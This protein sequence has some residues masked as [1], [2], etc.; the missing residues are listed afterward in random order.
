MNP[1]RI[2]RKLMMDV[3]GFSKTETNGLITLLM[4]VIVAAILPRT[5]KDKSVASVQSDITQW[6]DQIESSIAMSAKPLEEQ[7][8]APVIRDSFDPNTTSLDRMVSVGVPELIAKRITL[9]REKGGRFHS[10]E[11]IGKI[12]G[13]NDEL[14]NRLIPYVQIAQENPVEMV[15]E[16]QHRQVYDDTPYR[17][18]LNEVTPEELQLIRG[19]GPVL[20]IRIVEYREKL[21]G[22]H[23][24]DQ[25]SEI[26]GL[27]KDVIS[28]IQSQSTLEPN[29]T[30]IDINTDSVKVLVRHPYIDYNMARIIINYRRVHGNFE[31]PEDL[32][33]IKVMSDSLYQKLIPYLRQ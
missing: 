5:A 18:E 27:A 26:Y 11:D 13:M 10:P 17:F 25:L 14:R 4:I 7:R 6:H 24:Y 3:L 19:I 20:S 8:D 30:P 1:L 2:L 15:A 29:L 33:G 9:Y 31:R 28:Q 21:G 12:Y 16:T 23:S 22:F 32:R